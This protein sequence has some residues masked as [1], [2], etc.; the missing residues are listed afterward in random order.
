[1]GYADE[2]MKPRSASSRFV[3]W[4]GGLTALVGLALLGWVLSSLSELHRT[5]AEISAPL[6]NAVLIA[7]IVVLV[8]ILSL[9]LR[10]LWVAARAGRSAITATDVAKDP[11]AAAGQSVE[12]AQQQIE[13]I[14]DEIARQALAGELHALSDDLTAR[15]YTIVVFGTGSA[16]KTSV[17]NALLGDG[18]GATDPIVGTTQDGIEH[19]YTIDG[20]DEG[21]LRLVDTPGL[22]EMGAGGRM[23]E[24]RARELATQADLLLF[25]VDQDLRDIEFK[26]LA[27]LARLGKRSMLVFNKRDLYLPED[28]SAVAERLRARVAEFIDPQDVVVCAADPATVTVRDT[29]GGERSE[30]PEIDTGALAE[31]IAAILRENGRTLLA[32]KV[33]LQA[34]R[35]SER[36]R[37]IIHEMRVKQAQGVVTR[38]Q[39]TTAAVMFV[40]PVPGL[41]A[42]AAAAINY[43]M[44]MEIA[45]VFG[46]PVSL[47]A[48]KRMAGELGQVMLKMGVVNVTTNILGKALK[49]SIVGYV[50]GGAIEAVAGAYLTKLSG[51]AF[52]DHFAHDQDWGEN[53]MQGAIEKRFQLEGQHEF[54]A[55]FIKEAAD[56]VFRRREDRP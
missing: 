39:W 29:T 12:A 20:F 53:G 14:S 30:K 10:F 6:A 50:A 11:A 33:L 15:R 28:L 43:Q 16:G 40:N 5:L 7:L 22:S 55:A 3:A 56:R 51:E 45:K 47:E 54:V 4:T 37:D 21:R 35:I 13:L 9:G 46:A 48:A 2:L 19:L 49:A 18:V 24:Q 17:I 34:R 8:A 1:M 44:V 31:R 52:T 42:L 32:N 41:G 26:P 36:A 25:V 27:S 38:F 23:R